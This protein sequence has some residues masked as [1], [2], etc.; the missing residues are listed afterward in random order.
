[1]KVGTIRSRWRYDVGAFGT[2]PY[3]KMRRLTIPRYASPPRS[4]SVR[5]RSISDHAPGLLRR[6]KY[7][8]SGPICRDQDSSPMGRVLKKSLAIIGES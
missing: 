1:M 6:R 3:L 5:V 4:R 2:L 8:K 7:P